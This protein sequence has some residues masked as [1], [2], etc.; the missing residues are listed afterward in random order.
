MA[1]SYE[2]MHSALEAV[3]D[4]VKKAREFLPAEGYEDKLLKEAHLTIK[5][6]L[7]EPPRN[8]DVGT[9]EEQATRL[10]QYCLDKDSLDCRH[11]CMQSPK[12][13]DCSME[14]AQ[15]PYE[16]VGNGK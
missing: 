7:D 3:L 6:A 5:Q 10:R 15:M 8:C 13:F 4:L 12:A 16:E 11:Y 2:K 9:A 14:W 1:N